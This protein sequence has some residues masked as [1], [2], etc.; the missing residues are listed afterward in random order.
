MRALKELPTPPALLHPTGT[1]VFDLVIPVVGGLILLAAVADSVRRR[2]LTWGFLFLASSLGVYWM[3]TV[4]DWGQQLVYSPAF[5]QHHLLDWL[6]RKTPNDPAFMPFAY[7]VYWTVHALV[8][9]YIGQLLQKRFG[10]S[11]LKAVVVLSLPVNYA[12]DFFVEGIATKMGWW[13]YAPGI[14]PKI[15]WGG[16]ANITLLWTIGL[17]SVWPNLI[18]YWAG[19]PPVRTLNH[20]ELFFRL[21]RFTRSRTDAATSVSSLSPSP[22]AVLLQDRI[23]VETPQS[24]REQYDALLDYEVTIARWRFEAYRLLAWFSVFQLSFFLLLI[25]PLVLM[26][27][28]TGVDSVYVP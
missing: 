19:K 23:A 22:G 11:L 3:E 26:R 16:D 14:G 15:Q 4:G 9:L 1:W 5:A 10:W 2:R 7:A 20:L 24:K 13:S 12:W 28:L 17:M 25:V 8:V 6:P 18:A 21:D 27:W